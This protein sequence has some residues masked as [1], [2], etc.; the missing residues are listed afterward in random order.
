[1]SDESSVYDPDNQKKDMEARTMQLRQRDAL[2][3]II[4][5]IV[6][7]LFGLLEDERHR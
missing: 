2:F 7:L 6:G 4:V 5:P 1:M 3:E